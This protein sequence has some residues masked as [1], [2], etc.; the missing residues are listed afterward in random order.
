[1]AGFTGTSFATPHVAATLARC[2]Q[3]S[4]KGAGAGCV[5]AMESGAKDLGKPGRDAVYGYGLVD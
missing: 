1:V 3:H 5:A 2:V 4:G